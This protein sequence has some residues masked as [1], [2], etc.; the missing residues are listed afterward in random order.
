M[1]CTDLAYIH[2]AAFGDF[3]ERVAPEI[4]SILRRRGI[5]Q[6]K[7]PPGRAL[8]IVEMGC[9]SGTLARHIVAAGYQVIGFDLS[10]AM[11]RLARAKA[12]RARFRIASLTAARIPRCRAV[13]AIGEVITYVPATGRGT[14][15]PRPLRDLFSRVHDALPPGG[16]FIFD[17]IESGR[18]RAYP[19]KSRSGP[20]WVI[21][22]Q[23]ELDRPGRVLTRRMVTIRKS[24]RQYRRSQELHSVRIYSRPAVARALAD[25]GFTARLTRS[26]GRY[27]LI[28]GDVAVVAEKQA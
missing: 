14:R 27:R 25:A 2:D 9:G 17:F 12:G 7:N 4:V 28:A 24:G 6:S 16:L 10:P 19:M 22:T 13:V 15:L 5:G 11:I 21:A 3:A 18:R 23:A 1:Y 26:Y 20:G 8:P